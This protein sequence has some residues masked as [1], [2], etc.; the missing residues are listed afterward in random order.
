MIKVVSNIRS[1][2]HKLHFFAVDSSAA[3]M[4]VLEDTARDIQERMNVPGD[5]ITYPVNW[6]SAKQR[7]AFFATNGFG[8]GIPHERSNIPHWT[9][10]KAFENEVDLFGRHAAGP[11]FGL[12][13]SGAWWQ[14]RIHRGRWV[15]LKDVLY[16]ELGKMPARIIQALTTLFNSQ[17]L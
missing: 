16:E 6:D 15:V 12:M 8:G 17:E 1:A 7:R 5:P 14:S 13:P 9:V 10:T 2:V 3:A 4:K 11:V